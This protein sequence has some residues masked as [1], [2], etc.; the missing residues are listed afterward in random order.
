MSWQVRSFFGGGGGA[1]A[2]LEDVVVASKWALS[3]CR[4]SKKGN[5]ALDEG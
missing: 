3:S 1:V 5:R 4:L 2:G